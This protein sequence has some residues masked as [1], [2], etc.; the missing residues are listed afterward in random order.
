MFIAMLVEQ[1]LSRIHL[2]AAL[3]AGVAAIVL[4]LIMK[5]NISLVLAAI[6]ASTLGF[7]ISNKSAK[8][9]DDEKRTINGQ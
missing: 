1:V 4:K 5:N 6:L 8:F 3:T 9:S 7:L 2:I